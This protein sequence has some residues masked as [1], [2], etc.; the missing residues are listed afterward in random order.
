MKSRK[1]KGKV[2]YQVAAGMMDVFRI[3]GSAVIIFLMVI[4]LSNLFGWLKRD[5]NVTFS[6]ITNNIGDALF[7]EK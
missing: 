1:K 6:D 5:I 7:V 3:A 2:T 4:L